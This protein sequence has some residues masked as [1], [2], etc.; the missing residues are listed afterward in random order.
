MTVV[1]LITLLALPSAAHATTSYS[2]Y[3]HGGAY[4]VS[5]DGDW[6][7]PPFGPGAVPVLQFGHRDYVPRTADPNQKFPFILM[8]AGLGG[9]GR[10]LG[11]TYARQLASRGYAVRIGYGA[12]NATAATPEVHLNNIG[13]EIAQGRPSML[14]R[15]ADFSRS[16]LVGYS[17]GAGASMW[18][19]ANHGGAPSPSGASIPGFRLSAM[20]NM[21][22]PVNYY[23]FAPLVHRDLP[24]LIMYGDRD[25]YSLGPTANLLMHTLAPDSHQTI[26]LVRGADHFGP[27]TTGPVNYQNRFYTM[28]TA[29]LAAHLSGDHQARNSFRVQDPE[30]I[31]PEY[32]S[33]YDQTAKARA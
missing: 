11:E 2:D 18:E 20:V 3:S 27:V 14:A 12:A 31:R 16:A 22:L 17:A 6:A 8:T 15:K 5:E 4:A 23:A 7:P 32:Y 24:T 9:D 21:G 30:L 29:W 25:P 33:I 10:S 1:V 28:M 19:G 26:L 13:L